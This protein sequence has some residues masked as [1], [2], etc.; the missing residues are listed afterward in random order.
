MAYYAA[1]GSKLDGRGRLEDS[2]FVL[3]AIVRAVGRFRNVGVQVS[4][5]WHNL[6]PLVDIGL[7]DLGVP[8]PPPDNPRDDTPDSAAAEADCLLFRLYIS[9]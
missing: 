5:G 8:L 7:T 9:H 4:F 1:A 3:A 6:P 2:S